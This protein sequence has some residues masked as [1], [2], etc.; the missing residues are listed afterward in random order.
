MYMY[1]HP[2]FL[3]CFYNKTTPFIP[4]RPWGCDPS[5]PRLVAYPLPIAPTDNNAS[6]H[7][8]VTSCHQTPCYRISQWL[9]TIKLSLQE[10]QKSRVRPDFLMRTRLTTLP[11]RWV[12]IPV[13]GMAIGGHTNSK[14]LCVIL[15]GIIWLQNVHFSKCNPIGERRT[16]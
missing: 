2:L 6:R 11:S 13:V 14:Q 8:K 7:H 16:G 3:L 4:P 9:L 1:T 10:P 15:I 12:P 5:S